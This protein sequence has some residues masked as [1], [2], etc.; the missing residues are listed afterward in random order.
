[1]KSAAPTAEELLSSHGL[2]ATR[3]RRLVLARLLSRHDHPS[4]EE[5]RRALARHGVE[6]STATLYQNLKRLVE[7]GLLDGFAGTGGVTRYDANRTPHAHLVCRRCG[8]VLDVG[9]EEPLYPRLRVNLPE[10][11]RRFRGWSVADARLELRGTCPR[12]RRRRA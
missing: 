8:R 5:L 1:M 4:A 9:P 7:A 6:L 11:A 10:A 3:A 12:C 2:R